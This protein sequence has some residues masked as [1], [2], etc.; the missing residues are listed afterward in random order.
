[1]YDH[2]LVKMKLLEPVMAKKQPEDIQEVTC[3]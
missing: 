3:E 2:D 1:M